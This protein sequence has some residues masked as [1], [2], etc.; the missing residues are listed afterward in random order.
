MQ[1]PLNRHYTKAKARDTRGN[2][3][4]KFRGLCLLGAVLHTYKAVLRSRGRQV[5]L[6][7]GQAQKNPGDTAILKER[8]KPLKQINEIK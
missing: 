1:V 8:G 4:A 7:Q 6:V 5:E 2:L 3:V